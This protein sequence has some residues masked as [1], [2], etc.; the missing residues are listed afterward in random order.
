[1]VFNLSRKHNKMFFSL[2]ILLLCVK[3][4]LSQN[5]QGRIV[6]ETK[7]STRRFEEKLNDPKTTLSEKVEL[8]EGMEMMKEL[9]EHRY[10]LSYTKDESVYLLDEALSLNENVNNMAAGSEGGANY[11]KNFKEDYYLHRMLCVILTQGKT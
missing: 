9:L 10:I 3:N 8:K 6:Y 4:V 7:M 2:L 11:Y 5:Y 1:M